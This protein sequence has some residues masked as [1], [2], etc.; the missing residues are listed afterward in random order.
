MARFDAIRRIHYFW[1]AAGPLAKLALKLL[2]I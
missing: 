1:G 2:T